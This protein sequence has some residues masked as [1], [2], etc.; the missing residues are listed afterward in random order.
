[1]KQIG[2]LKVN[3]LK[4]LIIGLVIL[5]AISASNSVQTITVGYGTYSENLIIN[6]SVNGTLI[7]R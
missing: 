1:M 6:N 7:M 3:N 2:G 5:L 4:K